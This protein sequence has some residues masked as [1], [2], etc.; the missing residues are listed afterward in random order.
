MVS[1]T[2]GELNAFVCV[3]RRTAHSRQRCEAALRARRMPLVV[4]CEAPVL[5][6]ATR[7]HSPFG[8]G[9]ASAAL[10][11]SPVARRRYAKRYPLGRSAPF[12]GCASVGLTANSH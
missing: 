8:T 10:G 6:K 7:T 9:A 4:R 3:L 5:P 11:E 12:G 2:C 1:I